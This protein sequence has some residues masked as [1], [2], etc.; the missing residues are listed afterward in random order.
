MLRE[1]PIGHRGRLVVRRSSP[2]HRFVYFFVYVTQY[3]FKNHCN[4]YI[5][6]ICD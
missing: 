1:C 5:L 3:F 4:L 2:K 6:F